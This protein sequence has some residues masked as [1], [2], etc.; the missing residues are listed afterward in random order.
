MIEFG[1]SLLIGYILLRWALRLANQR[2][3]HREW[4]SECL[5]WRGVVLTGKR[6]HYCYAWDG[7]PVDETT[8]E[9]QFCECGGAT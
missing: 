7:L 4:R 9:I 3:A 5:R 6:A 2:C 8:D 1:V